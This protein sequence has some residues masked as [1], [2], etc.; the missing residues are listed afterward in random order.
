[1]VLVDNRAREGLESAW[2]LSLLAET[3]T[4]RILFDA[5]LD[6]GLLCRYAERLGTS[7]DVDAAVVSHPHRDHYGGLPCLARWAPGTVVYLPPSPSSLVSWVRGLGLAPVIQSRGM[8]IAPG[9]VLSPA[10]EG[11]GLREHALAAEEDGRVAVLLGCSHPG[12]GRL[13]AAAL[14]ALGRGRADLAIGGLH[15]APAGEVEALL[16]LADRVAPMHCSGGAAEYVATRSPGRYID[17]A[18]GTVIEL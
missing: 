12:P 18:A 14:A 5:G 3:R 9:A 6:P 13:A 4:T 17:A 10:L 7:L 15:N 11:G 1:M 16:S 8:G 2:G